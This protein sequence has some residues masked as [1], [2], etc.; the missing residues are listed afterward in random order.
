MNPLLLNCVTGTSVTPSLY[1]SIIIYPVTVT[2]YLVSWSKKKMPLMLMAY[3]VYSAFFLLSGKC[4]ISLVLSCCSKDLKQKT[5]VTA[6]SFIWQA[7]ESTLSRHEGGPTPKERPQS[8]LA[9]SFYMFVS[10]PPWACPMQIGLAKK[11][12][13]LFHLKFS[14]Q[15]ADILLFHFCGLFSFFCLL[16]TAILDFFFLF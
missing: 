3:A 13:Y 6:Q 16:A 10:S 12:A 5:S 15:S 9:S 14:L 1:R 11:G 7:K 4:E 2:S 8:V